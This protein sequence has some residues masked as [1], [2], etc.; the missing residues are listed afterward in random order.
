MGAS[1]RKDIIMAKPILYYWAPCPTCSV[2]VHYA[3]EHGIDLDLRDVEQEQPFAE[4]TAL[5]GDANNI[6]FLYV[7][8][9]LIE[10]NDAVLAKL[11]ELA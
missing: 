10:G 2:A 1:R 8:E 4:L 3:Q 11:A 9:E 6:P 7:D 5:G